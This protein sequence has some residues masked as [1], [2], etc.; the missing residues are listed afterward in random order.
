MYARDKKNH[1]D[2]RKCVCLICF[3][4]VKG[5]QIIN[6]VQ[7]DI[8]EKH[9]ISGISLLDERL[10]I[11]LCVSCRIVVDKYNNDDFSLSLRDKIFDYSKLKDTKPITRTSPATCSCLV[12]SIV[13][14]S[15]IGKVSDKK[16]KT[17]QSQT[18]TLSAPP[19][20]IKICSACL[21]Q[22]GRGMPHTCLTVDRYHNIKSFIETS[23]DKTDE[24]IVTSIL[25]N[26]QISTNDCI[27]LTR[28]QGGMPLSVNIGNKPTSTQP[29]ISVDDFKQITQHLDISINKS[30]T[31]A[32][33]LRIV[34]AKRKIIMPGLKQKLVESSH[35]LDELY[36]VK[37]L[38]LKAKI[39]PKVYDF[40]STPVVYCVNIEGLIDFVIQ[41][42][43]GSDDIE[44]K[45]GVD[46]GGGFLKICLNLVE[47][48]ESSPAKG[49]RA[50]YCDGIGRNLFKSTSVNK[51]MIL[52]LAPD[53]AETHMN[54]FKL[55]DILDMQSSF[56]YKQAKVATDLKMANI[57]LGLMSHSSCH[58]CSW[59]DVSR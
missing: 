50:R 25:K 26:K 1:N 52:A 28:P 36:A 24:K 30:L 8:I 9:I 18:S 16:G 48:K 29:S 2:C 11:V 6:K 58:P 55:W 40:V 7:S 51:L 32:K 53:V 47:T 13:R 4:K 54:M 23:P 21:T 49:K 43:G 45:I 35:T 57:L 33:D 19:I 46:G 15:A 5:L 37:M 34:S 41:E 12:C 38:N 44:F 20:S 10:P 14:S 42:R 39:S 3:K 56:E 27:R 17:C 22:I 59:C 31:L